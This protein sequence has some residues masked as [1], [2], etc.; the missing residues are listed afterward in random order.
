MYLTFGIHYIYIYILIIFLYHIF[1]WYQNV[2]NQE[3]IYGGILFS[4]TVTLM[5]TWERYT[6]GWK[7]FLNYNSIIQLR[8]QKNRNYVERYYQQGFNINPHFVMRDDGH[9]F[10]QSECFTFPTFFLENAIFTL[11]SHTI[12]EYY[13]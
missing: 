9:R 13:V 7:C 1:H 8:I 12:C 6:G 5:A 3:R 2:L 11:N 10:I 4:S